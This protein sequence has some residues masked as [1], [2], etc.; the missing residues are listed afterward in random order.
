MRSSVF[1][2]F[3]CHGEL[4]R[5]FKPAVPAYRALH[6]TAPPYLYRRPSHVSPTWAQVRIHWTDPRSILISVTHWTPATELSFSQSIIFQN[7]Y[8]V[9]NYRDNPLI[10]R[11]YIPKVTV[12]WAPQSG[13]S[14]GGANRTV[15]A[16]QARAV[17]GPTWMSGG[18]SWAPTAGSGTEPRPPV[19]FL[20]IHLKSELIFGHRCVSTRLQRWTNSLDTS[21]HIGDTKPE[22]G[23]MGVPAELILFR[24]ASLK[25]GTVPDNPERM[26]TVY[27]PRSL[28]TERVYK[29]G[30]TAFDYPHL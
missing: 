22:T 5:T 4:A 28:Y 19:N 15:R 8:T 24:K 2:G 13:T 27:L 11:R 9:A 21:G 23:Q 14:A 29:I 16:P 12:N 1:I 3:A 17:G 25:I 26:V 18:A 20:Y 10:R 7:F 30:A 6:G